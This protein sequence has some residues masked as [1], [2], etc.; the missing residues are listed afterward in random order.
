MDEPDVAPEEALRGVIVT[1][2]AASPLSLR[3]SGTL[4]LARRGEPLDSES[5]GEPDLDGAAGLRPAST[6]RRSAISIAA[7][8][9]ERGSPAMFG[10]VCRAEYC[11]L[12]SSTAECAVRR[13]WPLRLLPRRPE[14]R[15]LCALFAP[16]ALAIP[17]ILTIVERP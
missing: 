4:P 15:V 9:A 16:A 1:P 7:I 8:G 13:E 11:R 14:A 2:L 10:R 17:P 6:R 12:R 5:E 3:Q